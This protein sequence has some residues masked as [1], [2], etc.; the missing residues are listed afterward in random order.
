MKPGHLLP[1]QPKVYLHTY[2]DT[3]FDFWVTG[4]KFAPLIGSIPNVL[5][6]WTEQKVGLAGFTSNEPLNGRS[7]V[8]PHLSDQSSLADCYAEVRSS[9]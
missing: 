4:Y 3:G 6:E 2:L 1:N 9:Q 5:E 7:R 8:W